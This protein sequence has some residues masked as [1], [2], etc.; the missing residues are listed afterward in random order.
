[1]CIEEEIFARVAN[2]EKWGGRSQGLSIEHSFSFFYKQICTTK[3]SRRI[4][5]NFMVD[6]HIFLEF[7]YLLHALEV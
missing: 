4:L 2:H 7:A 3:I 1:M 6:L 5:G